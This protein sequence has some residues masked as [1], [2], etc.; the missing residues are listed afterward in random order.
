MACF[1]TAVLTIPDDINSFGQDRYDIINRTQLTHRPNEKWLYDNADPEILFKCAQI[2]VTTL[3]SQLSARNVTT[4]PYKYF[5]QLELGNTHNRWHLHICLDT[6]LGNPRTVRDILNNVE[7]I[8]CTQTLGRPYR[9]LEVN[10]NSNGS[11]RS[12]TEDFIIHYLLPKLPPKDCKYAWTNI[13]GHIGDAC[14]N[15]DKRK[16]DIH[17]PK[18]LI[19]MWRSASG[20]QM[21]QLVKFCFENKLYTEETYKDQFEDS[22]YSYICTAAG[23]HMLKQSIELA[24]KQAVASIPTTIFIGGWTSQQ[25]AIEWASQAESVDIS[26]NK[27]FDLLQFQGYDPVVIGFMLAAW[28]LRQTGRRNAIWLFGPAQTGK[29]IFAKALVDNVNRYGCVNWTN[30]NFPF[31]D[32]QD[33]QLG[34]WEEGLISEKIVEAAKALLGGTTLRIDRKCKDSVEITP[35]PMIITSNNDMT[36]VASGN[37]ISYVHKKPLEDRMLKLRFLKRLPPNYGIIPSDHMKLFMQWAY[38]IFHHKLLPK[39]QNYLAQPTLFPHEIPYSPIVRNTA[40][41]EVINH[42]LEKQEQED[43]A[44]LEEW[45]ADPPFHPK[46][47][48]KKQVL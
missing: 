41:V 34:W 16:G 6:S 22:Y 21:K 9:T 1:Y 27:V 39:E 29:T 38:F 5:C 19:P 18:K 30:E 43:L 25:A 32:L 2:F 8:Y 4:N 7:Q 15:I 24:A 3:E 13:S 44:E 36:L 12:E 28:G 37:T 48:P 17:S 46:E 14:T 11:W 40:K 42:P 26:G 20:E 47:P 33:V 31:Q 10:R 45:F 35:P 23:T